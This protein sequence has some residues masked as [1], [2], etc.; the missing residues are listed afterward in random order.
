M[1][2]G[3]R[4]QTDKSQIRFSVFRNRTDDIIDY[5]YLWNGN[6]PVD[7]LGT[8]LNRDDFRGDRYVNIGD[9]VAYGAELSFRTALGSRLSALATA[10]LVD[11]YLDLRPTGKDAATSGYTMQVFSNGAFLIAGERMRGLIRRPNT[12]SAG[13]ELQ[14]TRNC[15]VTARMQYVGARNDNYYEPLYG[16]YGALGRRAVNDYT[17]LDLNVSWSVTDRFRLN[18]R[19]EN[20]FDTRYE[21][22]MGFTSRGRGLYIRLTYTLKGDQ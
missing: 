6:V 14:A 4:Q 18:G 9:Q 15:V 17:L 20:L 19:I 8:D 10:S 3:I 5:V 11:G 12:M 1:E 7:S 21:E 16:P 13:L 22:I 2:F